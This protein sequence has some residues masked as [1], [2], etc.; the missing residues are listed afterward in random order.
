MADTRTETPSTSGEEPAA[1]GT[2]IQPFLSPSKGEAR[3]TVL[4]AVGGLGATALAALLLL[5]APGH[6]HIVRALQ[7]A[8][9]TDRLTGQVGGASLGNARQALWLAVLFTIVWGAAGYVAFYGFKRPGRNRDGKPRR[10][11]WDAAWKAA[12]GTRIPGH[13]LALAVAAGALI[14]LVEKGVTLVAVATE[15]GALTLRGEPIVPALIA[16]LAW[17]KWLIG[18]LAVAAAVMMAVSAAT[19]ALRP[20]VDVELGER[21]GRKPVVHGGEPDHTVPA[22]TDGGDGVDTVAETDPAETMAI[23]TVGICCSGG[24]IRSAGFSLGGLSAL[25]RASGPGGQGPGILQQADYLA[26]VSGGGYAAAAWRI[27]AGTEP[28]L[29]DE[30]II[31]RP[32]DPDR[33]IRPYPD[34]SKGAADLI[35]HVRERRRFLANGPGGLPVSVGIAVGRTLWHVALLLLVVVVVAWPLGWLIVTWPIV[36]GGRRAATLDDGLSVSLDAHNWVPPVALAGLALAVWAVRL[37]LERSPT[38]RTIDLAASGLAAAAALLAA[39][40]IVLPV[41]IDRFVW[42]I[43]RVGAGGGL[44][45]LALT[46]VYG[47][48]L[49]AVWQV[50][51]RRLAKSAK[52]LGGVLLAFG[53]L[54]FA[55]WV[56]A[57]AADTNGPLSFWLIPVIVAGLLVLAAIFLNPDR[58]SLHSLYRSRLATTFVT[59]FDENDRVVPLTVEPDLAEYA[60]AGGP[61]PV[62]CCA[63]ARRSRSHT[64]IPALS[65]TFEPTK[66]AVYRWQ[67]SATAPTEEPLSLDEFKSRLPPSHDGSQL[68]APM[69][70]AAVSGA[71]VAPSLGR[72][73]LRSTNA[74]LAAFNARLGVWLPNPRRSYQFVTTPRLVNM[75]KEILGL[76]DDDDPNL[77]ATDG[78]HWE[79]L[80]LVELIRRRCTVI[81][82]LDASGEPPGTY[83]TFRQA[84]QLAALECST[85]IEVSDDAWA[86][87]AVDQYGMCQK[88]YAVADISYPDGTTGKIL[89]VKA[90][91]MAK[92]SLPILRYA[93]ADVT[94]P[95]YSTGDQF[96]TDDE[97]HHLM[98]L[99]YESVEA[100]LAEHAGV[101][102]RALRVTPARAGAAAS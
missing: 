7:F 93:S 23:D 89:Y 85:T 46:G 13:H 101:R 66:V 11:H 19:A 25:E 14:G 95:H 79:N 73:S 94:F 33:T 30:P 6:W 50:A 88:N 77:Y 96:L 39:M 67:K 74:L 71:A 3:V 49:T 4:A 98:Q 90:A 38:R 92:T 42:L 61:T 75:F 15:G 86:G 58:W 31:G 81:I 2:D 83:A 29:R 51:K 60:S 54:G 10:G 68:A 99:G 48:I 35:Q 34:P 40:L 9:T 87:L 59:G 17:A 37:L 22:E 27:L 72:M 5:V 47:A 84:I 56:M 97:L 100:A 26:S 21:T 57:N 43:D 70:A 24:G 64:G 102:N 8:G 32:D 55:L 28:T 52:Y 63:V 41:A 91:V 69:G 53:L 80:G 18:G 62:L 76:Y 78:G 36:G 1:R 45:G 12:P 44:S 16:T 82:C 65:M 20:E